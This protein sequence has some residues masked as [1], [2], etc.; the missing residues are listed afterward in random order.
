MLIKM[1][2]DLY[3]LEVISQEVISYFYYSTA[4]DK[5][6]LE[7]ILSCGKRFK[8]LLLYHIT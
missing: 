1:F 4:S 3:N 2:H 8:M 7:V 5:I 6:L